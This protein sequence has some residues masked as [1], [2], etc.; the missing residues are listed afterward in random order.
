VVK[1]GFAHNARFTADDIFVALVSTA[2]LSSF[3]LAASSSIFSC[4]S[5]DVICGLK[6]N[7][8]ADFNCALIFK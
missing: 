6:K 4:S 7:N 2:S 1:L 3:I 5:F 8:F